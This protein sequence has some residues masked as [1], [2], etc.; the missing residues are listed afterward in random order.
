MAGDWEFR[1]VVEPV[2]R[3]SRDAGRIGREIRKRQRED[4]LTTLQVHDIL[5]ITH[6]GKPLGCRT[7]E[8]LISRVPEVV[9]QRVHHV[10]VPETGQ[11]AIGHAGV[12]RILLLVEVE[13]HRLADGPLV[14]LADG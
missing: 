13:L 3:A 7:L 12:L 11:G 6:A 8:W 2:F 9:L 14:R 5:R 10:R 4:S 1:G